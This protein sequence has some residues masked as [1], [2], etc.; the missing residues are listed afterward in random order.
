MTSRAV[1]D[2]PV[3]T[4]FDQNQIILGHGRLSF[5]PSFHFRCCWWASPII[6]HP[7]PW[8]SN[9]GLV[10]V[11]Q[12]DSQVCTSNNTSAP[13]IAA[14]H[15]ANVFHALESTNPLAK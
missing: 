11:T 14:M 6:R 12:R 15:R 3:L 10:K 1:R 2:K 8:S 9:A 7:Y 5:D 4:T 13:N